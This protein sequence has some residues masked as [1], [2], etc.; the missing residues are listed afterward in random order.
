MIHLSHFSRKNT[1]YLM[2][3]PG[4]RP[5]FGQNEILEDVPF[6]SGKV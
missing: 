2:V 1:E 6:D 3:P 5:M 4:F